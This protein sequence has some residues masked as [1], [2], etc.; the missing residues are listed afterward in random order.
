M[1]HLAFAGCG[2]PQ[3]PPVIHWIIYTYWPE[4]RGNVYAVVP[5]GLVAWLYLRSKHRA[6]VVAHAELKAAHVSHAEKLDK[7]L[8]K[9]DPESQGGIS[10][11]LDRL[12]IQTPGG[13]ADLHA[14]IVAL[15]PNKEK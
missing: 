13:I 7:L 6:I 4:V 2:R 1:P 10:D 15:N 8:D 5:C 9:L 14:E 12:D 11:V 3:S